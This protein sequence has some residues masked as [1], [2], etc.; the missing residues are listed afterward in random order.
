VSEIRAEG[1]RLELGGRTV[2][3]VPDLALPAGRLTTV[4]GP[5]GAG[6]TSLL[7]L[8]GGFV[9]P[10]TG[11]V[12]CVGRDARS[13]AMAFQRPVFL[14]GTV[15]DNLDLPLRLWGVAEAERSKRIRAG[16][17]AFDVERLLDRP[18]RAL[19]G[20]EAQRV[21]VLRALALSAPLTL[22]D[23]PTAGLDTGVRES[24]ARTIAS[25]LRAIG[26][27]SVVVTHDSDEALRRGDH[28]VVIIGGRVRA[29]GSPRE[30]HLHPGDADVARVLGYTVVRLAGRSLGFLPGE[31]HPAEEAAP[32]RLLVEETHPIGDRCEVT[33]RLAGTD[34]LLSIRLRDGERPVHP[35]DSIGLAGR[36]V[37]LG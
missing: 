12:R 20:G 37:D 2:L 5:N 6:K 4:L 16:A 31:L 27:T 3:D 1:V 8:L 23:E 33:G 26:G 18:A 11:L 19:S 22:L 35:G 17:A 30:V 9:A 10:T 25:T 13:T 36:F 14:R 32:L 34:A 15:R 29:A 24:L 28:L 21:N 7:R